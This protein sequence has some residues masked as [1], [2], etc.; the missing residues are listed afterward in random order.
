M[1]W[2]MNDS[3]SYE[4]HELAYL[5][6]APARAISDIARFGSKARSIRY[7]I[8]LLAAIC[9]LGRAF[10]ATDAPLWQAAFRSR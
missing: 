1:T 4:W 6:L 3:Y 8:R 7:P 10:R 9:R 2:A 5:A